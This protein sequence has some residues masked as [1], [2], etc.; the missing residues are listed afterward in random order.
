MN[1]FK[2]LL[3]KAITGIAGV[4]V[5]ALVAGDCAFFLLTGDRL[6]VKAEA[7]EETK[8]EALAPA[9]EEILTE[10]VS[11]ETE[12]TYVEEEPESESVLAEGDSEGKSY[13][14]TE[15]I[16]VE[17]EA[18]EESREPVPAEQ[19]IA[20]PG[21]AGHL[22]EK[23]EDNWALL[24]E[25]PNDGLSR[26]LLRVNRAENCI[27]VYARDEDGEYTIP[28]KAIV[29]STGRNNRTPLGTFHLQERYRWRNMLGGVW[30]QY[31]TRVYRGVMMHSVPYYTKNQGNL[32]V[33][34][35]NRLGEQASAGC[36][37]MSTA[38]AMWVY[39]F[40]P[41]GTQVEVYEDAEDPGPLGKP[42]PIRIEDGAKHWGWDPT[43]PDYPT[44]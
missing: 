26:F 42:E 13:G 39:Y 12:N 29:C 40:C 7:S 38:D 3:I 35:Y 21:A 18:E 44:E 6:L 9:G 15:T 2:N 23:E 25:P 31:A 5:F 27:T 16:G 19:L 14:E 34:Q 24:P 43:D 22:S 36:I 28:Y 37:R 4:A 30:S 41:P 8:Q 11:E 1:P 10:V 20:P 17:P 33:H 32:E